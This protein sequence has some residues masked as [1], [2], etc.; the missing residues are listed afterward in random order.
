MPKERN[1][2]PRSS[3][4]AGDSPEQRLLRLLRFRLCRDRMLQQF[5]S[6]S[7]VRVP[8]RRRGH[9]LFRPPRTSV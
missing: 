7:K 8:V 6:Q 9:I 5:Q 4:P 2:R 1:L 3:S